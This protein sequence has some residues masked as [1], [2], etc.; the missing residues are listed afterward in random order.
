MPKA[1][2]GWHPTVELKAAFHPL[3]PNVHPDIPALALSLL[4]GGWIEPVTLNLRNNLLVGGHHRVLAAQWL[5]AQSID[6][7]S[8]RSQLWSAVHGDDAAALI[9]FAPDYWQSSLVLRVNLS[10]E[11]HHAMLLRLNDVEAQGKDDETKLR[12]ILDGLPGRLR[13]L[14]TGKADQ[15]PPLEQPKAIASPADVPLEQSAAS[16]S[17]PVRLSAHGEAHPQDAAPA[18]EDFQDKQYFEAPDAI[19]KRVKDAPEPNTAEHFSGDVVEY[20]DEEFIAEE[21][22]EEE[23][24]LPKAP[25]PVRSLSISL[26]WAQWKLWNAYK[27]DRQISR[28]TD[29]FVKG[30]VAYIEAESVDA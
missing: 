5:S 26:T 12:S 23:E 16:T 20:E 2:V 19:D 29:A 28:D 10:E 6:W 9:R 11:E 24:E 21:E 8:H 1:D 17:S 18:P 27:R 7:F 14:A 13:S 22:E 3:N 15:K 30:H 4:E 25:P